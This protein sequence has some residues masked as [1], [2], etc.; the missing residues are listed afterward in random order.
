MSFLTSSLFLKKINDINSTP[1]IVSR[2]IFN[3]IANIPKDF[4]FELFCYL[5]AIK[6]RYKIIRFDVVYK[7][8]KI[9]LS[10]WNVNIFSKLRL[11]YSIFKYILKIRLFG[12]N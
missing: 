6:N 10:K 4:N 3:N 5:L 1:N 2:K 9:G 8:R 12:I 7:D 11:S